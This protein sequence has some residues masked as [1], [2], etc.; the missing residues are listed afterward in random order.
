MLPAVQMTMSRERPGGEAWEQ[1]F[2]AQLRDTASAVAERP[3]DPDTARL[4]ALREGMREGRDPVSDTVA[5]ALRD[6][7]SGGSADSLASHTLSGD[8]IRPG[9]TVYRKPFL[10][11]IIS[12]KNQDSLVYDVRNK[13]VHIFE[14]GDINYQNMNMKGDYMRVDMDH[15]EIFAHGRWDT[16]EM[17]NTRPA[18]TDGGSA[19]TMD[20]I[21]YNLDTKKARIKGIATEDGEGFLT[22]AKVKK[23]SDDIINITGGHYTTCDADHPHF[24]LHMSRA[25]AIPGKKV[26]VGPSYL[27]MEDVPIYFLGLPFGFFPT[28]SG[29]QSGFI[30]PTWGEE[31]IKGFFLRDGGYYFAFNDYIDAAVTGGI[32]T[33]GSW[34]GALASRYLK[35]YRYSGG[36]NVRFTKNIIGE[37]GSADYVNMNA[38]SVTWSHQ[39]DP[40]FRPNSSFAASVNFSTS[41]YNKYG[42]QNIDEY[43]NTQTNSSVS[44][45]KTWAGTPFSLS[46]NIQYSQNA[47]DTMVSLSFPNVVFNMSRVYPF[48]RK[49]AVGKQ[50]WYEKIALS[51][52][53]SL[54]NTV[55]TKEYDLFTDKMYKNMRNGV[56][57]NIPISSSFTLFKYINFS[58]SANYRERWYFR[59]I[60][61]EWD[62]V[63][64][65]V[66]NSDTVNG[67]YRVYD[68]TFSAALGTKIYGTFLFK[69]GAALEAV[70]HV[71]TPS[72][73]FSYT[74]DFGSSRFGYYKMVQSD[75]LGNMTRYSPFTDGMY[76]VPSTGASAAIG[77]S[78]QQ[79][80]E[81]KVRDRRDT[82]GV[83][84][85][86][87][88]DDLSI[89]S[90]Y[91]L[92]ADSM[93]LAPFSI[94]FRTSLFKNVAL[95]I[96]ATLDPYQ[97][98]EKGKRY[99]RFMLRDGKLGRITNASTSFGYSFNSPKRSGASQ[100][101]VNDI[102]SPMVPPNDPN[103]YN[104]PGWYDLDPN[105]Q[106]ALMSSVYYDFNIP[107]NF[108][109]NY[110]IS[111]TNNGISKRISQTLGFQG[112][113]SL[114]PKWGV[115]F[116]G[117]YDFEMKRLTPGT[118]TVTRDL[119]CWQM[120]FN[121]VPIGF[122]KSWS[123]TI[124]VKAGSLSD[125]KYDRN[126]SFYDQL[127]E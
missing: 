78:L 119:H 47:Q 84:K 33:M 11:D 79:T 22:G 93:N 71:I 80:L 104:T 35:K 18:F 4:Q 85:I 51:Y 114:T 101:A 54:A 97:V 81:I 73:S 69:K 87:L 41:G 10:D 65:Q 32:Y 77:F 42:A 53:G 82:T 111:Y 34:E 7:L 118:I 75:T 74:P 50:R 99:N 110:S 115:S 67:F 123:F 26:I 112:S 49:N 124:G 36:L 48:R 92:I 76:G 107:W 8:S 58:P 46:A 105:T 27:V 56:N 88:I 120:S 103:Y 98:D 28:T 31:A 9:D 113:I 127:Y 61:R 52:T 89:R 38:F 16:M 6:S 39:Q 57:H 86:K 64:K 68:Y 60:D 122:R 106:R 62:P 91:N 3:A 94:S 55:N 126:S 1:D 70:R 72:V 13:Q 20:T 125:L 37:K 2:A 90:S 108:G 15:R 25:K 29:R 59:K 83:R 5:A 19:F 121:W 45:S 109:F 24:Y 21:T 117:G 43:L 96:S 66:V 116:N 23:M 17:V 102:N 12:G 14:K 100:P 95:N 44:Y 30:V 63:A 40:K